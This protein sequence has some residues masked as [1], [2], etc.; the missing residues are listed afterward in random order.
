MKRSSDYAGL[1]QE[2]HKKQRF[3]QSAF[4]GYG[5][6][7]ASPAALG[8][9]FGQASADIYGFG[10]MG[11]FMGNQYPQQ[12]GSMQNMS[13][14]SGMN[15]FQGAGQY[16]GPGGF[17]MGQYQAG[18]SWGN[19]AAGQYSGAAQGWGVQPGAAFQS[20]GGN[21]QTTM[22]TVYLGNLPPSVTLEEVVNHVKGGM[23][24]QVKILDEKN[25][26]FVTFVESSAAAT[27]FQEAQ[28]RR[29]LINGQEVKIGWGKQSS[30]PTNVLTAVQNGAS[31]NVFVGNI[32]DTVTE[33][34]LQ[35]EFAK[36]GTIDQVK[37]IPDKRIAFVHMGSISSAMKAV[38]N[39]QTDPKWSSRRVNYGKDRCAHQPKTA[40]GGSGTGMGAGQSSMSMGTGTGTGAGGVGG[41]GGAIGSPTMMY[42]NPGMGYQGYNMGMGY[43]G[44]SFDGFGG[45]AT[46]MGNG[47][48]NGSM[49]G[50]NIGGGIPNR[51][52]YLGG[53]HPDVTTKELCDV[54]RGGILQNI[55]YM[56]DKNIAFVTFIDPNAAASFFQR[57]TM[58]G[59]VLKGKRVK[60]GWGKASPLPSAVSQAVQTGASRNV[61][62]G[63]LDDTVTE[64]RLRKDFSEFGDIELINIIN[65]KNIGFVNF[66]DILSAVRAV[67][68]M[69]NA[70]EYAR[71]KINYGKD[72]CGNAPRPPRDGGMG[73]LVGGMHGG[74][75]GGG[76]GG[77]G[78]GGSGGSGSGGG[79]G[80]GFARG[81][82]GGSGGGFEYRQ[83][84]G[85]SGGGGFMSPSGGGGF[86]SPS[87]SPAGNRKR[88][89]QTNQTIMPVT[90]KMLLKSQRSVDST[91]M[92]DGVEVILVKIL[93]M[94]QKVI[95]T[96]VGYTFVI[97]DT[98]GS[99]EVKQ[100]IE[101][102]S[103]QEVQSTVDSINEGDW[104]RV[105]GK[106]SAFQN[107]ISITAFNMKP[108]VSADEVTYHNLEVIYVHLYNTKGPLPPA[109]GT[110]GSSQPTL[111]ASQQMS[112]QSSPYAPPNVA[113]GNA[114]QGGWGGYQQQRG[115][116]GMGGSGMGGGGLGGMSGHP[117]GGF[118]N[119]N[120][121]GFGDGM[122]ALQSEVMKVLSSGT[123]AD[124]V[125]ISTV[126]HKLRGYAS[127]QDINQTLRFLAEE[128]HVYSTIDDDHLA[129]TGQGE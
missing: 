114:G 83:N 12:G 77:A 103:H 72:R 54:I 1:S 86:G 48:G 6:S 96:S 95:H 107:K 62:I 16:S 39:L 4:G 126:F 129:P 19:G 40:A 53:I 108:V 49:P 8:M 122:T 63:A 7:A 46:A 74:G 119:R 113:Q 43:G 101:N 9:G 30:M 84:S 78:A 124:G 90:V 128:G 75:R 57:G 14:Y 99:I 70:P 81:N 106:V 3:N 10:S 80:G 94:V 37:I 34:F 2:N 87:D 50:A 88:G 31:R 65:E 18:T 15:Q 109:G 98:S 105:V 25:C 27:F 85:G 102:S 22:R 55:K 36:F 42:G 112:Y 120:N 117:Q 44:I 11:Q 33:N 41:P 28:S 123:G 47:M 73:G 111:S 61:Y 116:A 59:V 110:S 79:G 5:I 91:I 29:L 20:A 60:V 24:E 92:I 69:K 104:V 68:T 115:N 13:Q 58:E 67:D 125:H 127:E 64:D 89:L 21:V 51:T 97:Q 71:F 121:G 100:F 35:Q 118:D 93:G 52:I 45:A 32:D 17:S 26:A 56:P 82:S 38:A 23:V 76:A 66:T